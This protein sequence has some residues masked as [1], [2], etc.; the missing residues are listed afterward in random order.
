MLLKTVLTSQAVYYLTPLDVPVEVKKKIDKI[1][2]A[3]LWAGC[4]KV[5]GGKCK[6]NWDMVCH[7]KRLGGLGILNLENFATALRLRW[8]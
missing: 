2:R 6:M 4:D 3:F 8:L 5:S 1:R 7:P